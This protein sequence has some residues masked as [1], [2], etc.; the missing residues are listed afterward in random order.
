MILEG[1]IA[2]LRSLELSQV[3]TA[4][5]FGTGIGTGSRRTVN[6]ALTAWFQDMIHARTGPSVL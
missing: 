4:L 5:E 3:P 2:V 6:Q 1:S